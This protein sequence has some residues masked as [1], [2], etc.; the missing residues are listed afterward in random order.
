MVSSNL[1]KFISG[2]ELEE[3]LGLSRTSIWRY[4]REQDFPRAYQ[5]SAR[6]IGFKL[7]EVQKWMEE[8]PIVS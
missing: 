6:R 5:L 1:C 7:H 8:R 3:L 2:K 4:R